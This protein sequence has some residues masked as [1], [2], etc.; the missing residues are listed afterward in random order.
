MR[1]G[2]LVMAVIVIGGFI[3][4]RDITGLVKGK[5]D[6]TAVASIQDVRSS[7]SANEAWGG[8]VTIAQK[9]DLPPVLKEVSGIAYM[10]GDRFA[11]IQDEQG[12]IYIYNRAAGKVEKEIRFGAPGDYE[13]IALVGEKAWVV[14][15]DGKLFEVDM[16]SGK[17]TQH[18]T[19]L[20]AEHN[21]EGLVYDKASNRLLLAIKDDEPGGADYKGIYGF[22]L[23]GKKMAKE[24][25]YKIDMTNEAFASDKG[26]KKGKNKSVKPSAIGIHP[27]TGE[28]YV[29]DGPKSRLLIMEKNGNLKNVLQL[30]KSFEQPEGITFSPSGELYISNEGNKQPG[31][32]LAVT[33]P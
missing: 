26:K 6:N 29:T 1:F 8:G 10:D 21:V 28:I 25:V 18:S 23:A 31:N 27:S 19:P 7:D 4:W 33:L 17:A 13:D 16:A 2:L 15:S 12:V 3:F 11:C 14:R 22:D 5:K 30:G 20:T 24:P 9:W 32:I